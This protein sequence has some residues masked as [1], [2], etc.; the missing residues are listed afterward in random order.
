MPHS[1]RRCVHPVDTRRPYATRA[2]GEIASSSTPAVR[3]WAENRRL[4]ARVVV[5]GGGIVGLAT[6]LELTN[7]GHQVT[8]LEKEPRLGLAPDRAQL[9]RHPLRA[10]LQARLAE[11]PDVPAPAPLDGRLRRSSTASRTTSAASSSS[12]SDEAELPRLRSAARARPGQRRCRSRA[13]SRRPRSREHE[14]HVAAVA[15]APRR[16]TGHHR[17]RR[18]QPAPGASWPRPAVPTCASARE[19]TASSSGRGDRIVV[20]PQR[21]R[22][23]AP[24]CWSTARACTATGSPGWP[25]IEPTVRIVPFR[26]EYYELDARARRTSSRA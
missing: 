20:Q 13:A 4:S 14:P 6:A 11:G 26:G 21:G 23:R 17:L 10:L 24:I 15:G 25:G 3:R 1:A 5:V 19:V 18:G 16:A 8:V 2:P 9:R 12:P 7:R 22:R